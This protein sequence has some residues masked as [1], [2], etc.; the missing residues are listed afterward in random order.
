MLRRHLVTGHGLT[1]EQ[2]RARWKLPR[3]HPMTAPSYSEQRS[4]L[5]KRIGL[6]RGRA[7]SASHEKPE[8]VAPEIPAAPQPRYPLPACGAAGSRRTLSAGAIRP[9]G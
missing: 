6:G 2:Y 8:R 7:R 1:V 4:S 9:A 3:E 5:A